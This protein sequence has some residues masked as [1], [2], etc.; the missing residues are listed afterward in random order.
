MDH[1]SDITDSIIQP[2]KIRLVYPKM[3]NSISTFPL[4]SLLSYSILRFYQ[5]LNEIFQLNLKDNS[6]NLSRVVILCAP[7]QFF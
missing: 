7:L 5:Y 6:A 1:F 2:P 4:V 3:K